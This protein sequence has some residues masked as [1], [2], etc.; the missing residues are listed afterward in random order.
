MHCSAF[1]PFAHIN[2]AQRHHLQI[3]SLGRNL[4]LLS[5][6]CGTEAKR[7][8]QRSDAERIAPSPPGLRPLSSRDDGA[9]RSSPGDKTGTR[10]GGEGSSRNLAFPACREER[11]K[12]DSECI[13]NRTESSGLELAYCGKV[14]AKEGE[15]EKRTHVHA[16]PHR[17]AQARTGART[18]YL[19]IGNWV[20]QGITCHSRSKLLLVFPQRTLPSL[21]TQTDFSGRVCRKRKHDLMCFQCRRKDGK[22]E[23]KNHLNSSGL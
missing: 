3:T 1:I 8:L 9:P 21:S 20:R 11:G 4:K 22:K 10:S 19:E 23:E 6:S 17:H 16:R 2:I 12:L 13:F 18:P 7:P 5:S 15:G 14:R